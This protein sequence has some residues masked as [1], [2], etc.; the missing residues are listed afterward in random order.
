MRYSGI[1]GKAWNAVR[2]YVKSK[3]TDCYTCP[4]TGLQGYNAQVGH[5]LPVGHVGSNN[6]LSWDQTQLH[7][8]C[9]R[10]NGAG[11]GMAVEYRRHLVRDYGEKAVK[12]LEARRYKIDPI[13]DWKSVIAHFEALT[14]PNSSFI[15]Y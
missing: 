11:Q 14:V 10:C 9:G 4:A 13:K 2:A 15:H 5:Y 3:E 1:K 12:A 6:R 8:Q 7:L